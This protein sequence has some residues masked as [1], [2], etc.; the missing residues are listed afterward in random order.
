MT[1]RWRCFVAV[2]IGAETREALSIALARWRGEPALR[3]LRWVTPQ[4]WHVTLAFLGDVD[5]FDVP[6]IADRVAAA[7]GGHAGDEIP[8]GGV[9]AFPSQRRARVIW[10]GVRD[11]DRRLGALATTVRAA[12]DVRE[13]GAFRPHVTLARSASAVDVTR[14]IRTADAPASRLQIRD[15]R[16]MRSHLGH[17]PARHE[18]LATIPLAV[19]AHV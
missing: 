9:G 10:Y 11:A 3:E 15:V 12:L 13:A 7:V 19:A 5:P 2:P 14:W 1:E 8:I 17:G 16:V 18:T 4:S 6:Q